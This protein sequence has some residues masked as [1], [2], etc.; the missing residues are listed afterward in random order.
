MYLSS[1]VKMKFFL[2]AV[3]LL[4]MKFLRLDCCGWSLG[5]ILQCLFSQSKKDI[6]ATEHVLRR[7]V[8]L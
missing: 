8:E 3:F 6:E 4:L 7:A 5:L 2:K 1:R